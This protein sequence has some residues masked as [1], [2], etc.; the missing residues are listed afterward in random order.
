MTDFKSTATSRAAMAAV[1]PRLR[2]VHAD[3]DHKGARIQDMPAALQK[4]AEEKSPAQWSYERL[5]MYIS[6]FEETLDKDHE[7]AMGFAGGDAGVMR[8]EGVGFFDPDMITFYGTDESGARTQLV[9]HIAQLSVMLRAAPR[10]SER[11]EPRR[12]GF[13]LAAELEESDAKEA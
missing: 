6:K 4:P 10:P 3:P 13:R 2:E 12:I 1:R 5:I 11:D 7:V 8:I 9:Q